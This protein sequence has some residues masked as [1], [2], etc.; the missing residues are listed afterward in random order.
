MLETVATSGTVDGLL[1]RLERATGSDRDLDAALA[2]AF[3][4]AAPAPD[5]TAS[6]DRCLDLVRA[7]LPGWAWHVGWNATGILPYATL[8]GPQGLVAAS[9]ATVPL[10]LL[11]ALLRALSVRAPG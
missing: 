5:Y 8:H 2:R 9:A 3:Q 4:I 11:K 10:A 1:D 7:L 6:V